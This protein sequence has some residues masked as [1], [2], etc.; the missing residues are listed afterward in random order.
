[1]RDPEE[2]SDPEPTLTEADPEPEPDWAGMGCTTSVV[3]FE[4]L[5]TVIQ[6]NCSYICKSAAEPGALGEGAGR[7]PSISESLTWPTAAAAICGKCAVD[8][9]SREIRTTP[10]AFLKPCCCLPFTVSVESVSSVL[11]ENPP[12]PARSDFAQLN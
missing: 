1:M 3:L 11:T 8:D 2:M 10:C 6:R 5:R 9:I 12:Y 4:G 7:T